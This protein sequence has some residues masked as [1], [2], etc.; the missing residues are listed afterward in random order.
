M[1]KR[2]TYHNRGDFFWAKQTEDETPEEFWRRLIEIE[3]ECNFNAIS[4]EEMLIS[5]YMTAITDKKL[6]DK[7]LKAKTLELKKIIEL[8]KQNT[9]EKKNKKNTIPEALISTK[10]KHMI[11]EEPIQRME[12]FGTRPKNKN[13]GNRTCRFCNAPNWTPI[14]KC[15]ALEAHCNKS[16]KKGHHAKA[17]R[18][19]FNN[20]EQW[21]WEPE[22][23][24]DFNRIEQMLTEG[25]CL[26]LYAKEKD[27]IV[28][29]DA[30]TTGLG[31]TIWQK[32]DD[33]NTKPIAYGSR[34]LNQTEKKYSI[35]E[36]ELLAVVWGLEKFRFI[37]YGKKVY[38]YTD[39]Q[40]LE[41]LIKRNRSNKQYSARLTRWLDRLTH[42]DISIQHIAGSNLKFTDNLSRNS[43]GGAT[44]EENYNQEYVNNI[45]TEQAELNLKY[46]QLF[47]NQSESSKIKTETE[48]GT[49]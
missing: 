23:E 3:K 1:P 9:Y 5:K 18:Q 35:D 25:T 42:F 4:A 37:L 44:P 26:A 38:L 39:H 49:S 16:G 11:K 32:E 10:E 2:I 14:R 33:G 13:Y 27:N 29:T 19:K 41:P 43:V 48:N 22:Q 30:S 8:I 17:C 45:L 36:L 28:T 12:R 46:G 40:A 34:Y 24:M 47:A 31:I 21:K 7:I 6:R 20:N 15:P